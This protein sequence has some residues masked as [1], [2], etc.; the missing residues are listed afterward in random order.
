[1]ATMLSVSDGRS[2]MASA[3]QDKSTNG[4]PPSRRSHVR[5]KVTRVVAA[6]G[7][8]QIDEQMEI[9]VQFKLEAA[10][11]R[12]VAV[13]G[14]FNNWNPKK[15]PLVKEANGW[16]ATLSLPRGSYE[17][18]FVVDGAWMSDPSARESVANGYGESNS[19]LSV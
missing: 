3:T 2:E 8:A 14:S 10:N 5:S 1:M 7:D 11:A 19:V 16:T 13:A 4:R 9:K 12:S 17:Y 6:A 18:R 15:T